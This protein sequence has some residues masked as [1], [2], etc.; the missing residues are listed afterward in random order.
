MAMY[1]RW[2][3]LSKTP[4]AASTIVNLIWTDLAASAV[5]GTKGVLG[6]GNPGSPNDAVLIPVQPIVRKI[7][8][9]Y[10]F[11]I[12]A[13]ILA[14]MLLFVSFIA[15]LC[16]IFTRSNLTTM[17]RHLHQSSTGRILTVFLCPEQCDMRTRSKAW[18]EEIG[19]K[20]ID[21]SGERPALT[22]V[23]VL[24]EANGSVAVQ[25]EGDERGIVANRPAEEVRDAEGGGKSPPTRQEVVLQHEGNGSDIAEN[26]PV[27]KDMEAERG[28]QRLPITGVVLPPGGNGSD[29]VENRAD[30]ERAGG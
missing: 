3:N 16:L 10:L 1:V 14:G 20:E 6:P 19:I 25:P 21:L 27:D 29:I 13:F 8:Y 18:S 7:K 9:H 2:Q 30:I 5:V 15:L 12:P 11:A 22:D 23:A 28:D 26:T 24:P 17:R 4:E